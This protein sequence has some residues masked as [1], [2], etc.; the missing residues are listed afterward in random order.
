MEYSI[1]RCKLGSRYASQF[2]EVVLI[3]TDK[4]DAKNKF[5]A[6]CVEN[7]NEIIHSRI[8]SN[9]NFDDERLPENEI[10][11][12]RNIREFEKY[13]QDTIDINND[14]DIECLGQCA[15]DIVDR[16]NYIIDEI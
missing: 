11:P 4:M 3:A 15:F 9:F 6:K 5:I 16:Y 2:V 7:Y 10:M 8:H 14:D 1:F 12:L 13:L